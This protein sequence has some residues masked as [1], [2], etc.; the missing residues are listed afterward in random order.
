VIVNVAS[1]NRPSRHVR[2][3]ALCPSTATRPLRSWL[4]AINVLWVALWAQFGIT[5]TSW[6]RLLALIVFGIACG[7]TVL[8]GTTLGP[9]RPGVKR[10]GVL[11]SS[12]IGVLTI[13]AVSWAP[14]LAV[15]AG[16]SIVSRS[17]DPLAVILIFGVPISLVLA[18]AGFLLIALLLVAG[19]V[20]VWA[21]LAP[22]RIP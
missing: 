7:D 15:G 20:L 1:S 21:K 5:P 10:P 17:V 8:Y 14:F 19:R 18:V 11:S 16:F 3:S 6:N 9:R 4:V 13:A 12:A 2:L 22:H